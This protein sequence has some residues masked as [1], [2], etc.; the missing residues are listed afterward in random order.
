[1]SDVSV[2]PYWELTFDADGDVD[3][4]QLSALTAGL[5]AQDVTDLVLFSH[6]W[7]SDRSGATRLYDRFFKP[8]P[9]L[10][11]GASA[12]AR[13]G[14]VGV[15][16]PSMRFSDEPIPDF[17]P[18]A[19]AAATGPLLDEPTQAAL[20]QV[21]PG[22]EDVVRQLAALL[23]E[24]P[25]GDAHI[26]DFVRLVRELTGISGP[27][28]DATDDPPAVVPAM[29]ADDPVGV[30]EV[31]ADALG[32]GPA[33][34]GGLDQRIWNGAHEVLRQATYYAMKRRA[35]TVGEHGL[36]PALGKLATVRPA[37]RVHLVGH[38]F[39]GRLVSFALRGLPDGVRNVK[40]V[41]LL[42]GAFSHYAFAEQLPYD[43]AHS[44]ALR[45][46]HRRVDGPVVCCY[47]SHD[48]ALGTL[49]PLASKLADDSRGIFELGDRWGAMGHDG[50]Q[51]VDACERLSLAE[52]LAGRF[53]AG[54]CVSVDASAVV[55]TGGPPSGAHS[56]IC[57]EELARVVLRA[58]RLV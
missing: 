58:G 27:A 28:A 42:Q 1:M 13:I 54:G 56:D 2:K 41:T 32:D 17:D 11:Q 52:A 57:H 16:W 34:L 25:D 46:A 51:A 50:I 21:F 4:I 6:G 47:S 31:F 53:P 15:L 30:C 26:A 19:V 5:S 29:L 39:G 23:R 10:V 12:K 55:K 8:I 48:D 38:S 14:Y 22:H 45:D 20:A 44:G 36:G 3:I 40:S 18:S 33:L 43:K 24:R 35:G 7:N 9:A 49:Y 37:L